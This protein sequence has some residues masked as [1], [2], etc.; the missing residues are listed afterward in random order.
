MNRSDK[1]LNEARVSSQ[2]SPWIW[3]VGIGLAVIV[4]GC[5]MSIHPD[6]SISTPILM[7]YR[8]PMICLIR[9]HLG[10]DCLTCG[11]T[12]SIVHLLHGRLEQ[13]LAQHPLGGLFLSLIILQIP[14]GLQIRFRGARAWRPSN[15][16]IVIGSTLIATV[17]ILIR[18]T[19]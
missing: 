8:L 15:P 11:M 12:R 6:G 1:S 19:A 14:Y 9:K 5:T 13:S 17:L 3:H 7:G 4:V 10:I 16:T 2:T 18:L